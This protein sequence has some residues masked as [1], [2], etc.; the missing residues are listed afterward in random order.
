MENYEMKIEYKEYLLENNKS[1]VLPMAYDMTDLIAENLYGKCSNY[2]ADQL[3]E[4]KKHNK[5]YENQKLAKAYLLSAKV[6]LNNYIE[7]FNEGGTLIPLVL[8]QCCH[9]ALELTLKTKIFEYIDEPPK[10][11]KNIHDLSLIWETI[12]FKDCGEQDEYK[13]MYSQLKALEIDSNGSIAFRYPYDGWNSVDDSY[14][15]DKEGKIL[16]YN[17]DE[18]LEWTIKIFNELE[19]LRIV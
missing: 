1:N 8:G 11:L 5:I 12:F 4:A 14:W 7:I 6:L 2:N 18:Y 19:T 10:K 13:T 9:Q 17:I 3:Y 15:K 16:Q